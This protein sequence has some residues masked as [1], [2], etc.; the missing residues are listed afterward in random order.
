M[1]DLL[2]VGASGLRAYG[3]ALS[4]VGDNIANAQTPGY[5]RRTA[6][7]EELAGSTASPTSGWSMDHAPQVLTRAK[8]P[9]GFHG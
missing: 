1:S 7:L 9:R 8:P 3:R 6:R 5:A 4:N 2:S